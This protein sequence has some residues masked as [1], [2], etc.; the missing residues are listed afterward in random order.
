MALDHLLR[1]A[2]R[3][4]LE[5]KP[6]PLGSERRE[7]EDLEEQVAELVPERLGIAAVDRFER[8]VTFLEKKRPD[9]LRRLLLVP[10]A[11]PP[12]ALDERREALEGFGSRHAAILFRRD[13]HGTLR[14]PT[15]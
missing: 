5:A 15:C 4:V 6:A 10:R 14:R 2:A 11:L 1:D 7:K 9:G 13:Q 8:F 3:H 12:Q